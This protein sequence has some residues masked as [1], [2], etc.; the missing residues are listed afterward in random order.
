MNKEKS[1]K[2]SKPQFT[3]LEEMKNIN[4]PYESLKPL[5][6]EIDTVSM[7]QKMKEIL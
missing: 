6:Q 1:K 4:I 3:I 5:E 2:I 7:F